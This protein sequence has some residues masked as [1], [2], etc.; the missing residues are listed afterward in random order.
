MD[1]CTGINTC[2]SRAHHSSWDAHIA[3][4]RTCAHLTSGNRTMAR[5]RPTWTRAHPAWRQSMR[6]NVSTSQQGKATTAEFCAKSYVGTTDEVRRNAST[7]RYRTLRNIVILPAHT[8]PDGQTQTGTSLKDKGK[9]LKLG[10][11]A[12]ISGACFHARTGAQTSQQ[13][14]I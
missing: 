14:R 5:Y 9:Y 12:F 6:S 8:Y 7:A 2:G 3:C 4:Y 10:R 11:K 1:G 13:M